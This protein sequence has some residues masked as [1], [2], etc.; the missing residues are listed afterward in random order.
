MQIARA[1]AQVQLCEHFA[2]LR[3]REGRNVAH[4]TF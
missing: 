3:V 2:K 1:Y 4:T